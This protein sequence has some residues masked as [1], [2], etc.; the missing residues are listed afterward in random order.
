MPFANLPIPYLRTH[1]TPDLLLDAVRQDAAGTWTRWRMLFRCI[2]RN[3]LFTLMDLWVS[4]NIISTDAVSHTRAFFF[5][6]NQ[7]RIFMSKRI[8]FANNFFVFCVRAFGDGRNLSGFLELI[9]IL[10]SMRVFRLIT[11]KY[12][13]RL[14]YFLAC[15]STTY[16]YG[17]CEPN[18]KL[19]FSAH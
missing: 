3:L 8:G 2:A 1:W 9:R 19:L 6:S 5:Y 15:N 12:I 18:R 14:H 11:W 16:D 7:S 17:W 4:A 13:V 10:T